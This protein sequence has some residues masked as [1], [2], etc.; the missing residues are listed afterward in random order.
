MDS[1]AI[2][3]KTLYRFV[4]YVYFNDHCTQPSTEQVKGPCGSAA[5]LRQRAGTR[6]TGTEGQRYFGAHLRSRGTDFPDIFDGHRLAGDA[7]DIVSAHDFKVG[8]GLLLEILIS[9]DRRDT[10]GPPS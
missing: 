9:C 2:T 3:Y 4:C 6:R 8:N 1:R 5:A 7:L 10:V